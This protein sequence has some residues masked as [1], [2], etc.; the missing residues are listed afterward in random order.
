MPRPLGESLPVMRGDDFLPT[1]HDEFQRYACRR[2][3]TAVLPGGSALDSQ[4][5]PSQGFSIL[6]LLHGLLFWR[7]PRHLSAPLDVFAESGGKFVE[8]LSLLVR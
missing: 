5:V 8:L 1:R 4:R 7:L 3:G 2:P 6:L